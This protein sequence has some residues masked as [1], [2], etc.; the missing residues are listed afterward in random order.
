M[1]SILFSFLKHNVLDTEFCFLLQAKLYSVGLKNTL[2]KKV[3]QLLKFFAFEYF[4][5][6]TDYLCMTCLLFNINQESLR[7]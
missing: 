1:S 5:P 7:L 3:K 2:Y 4:N 6:L